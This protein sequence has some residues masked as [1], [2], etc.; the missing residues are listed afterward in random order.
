MRGRTPETAREAARKKARRRQ[1]E[2]EALMRGRAAAEQLAL[3]SPGWVVMYGP[4]SRRIW[5]FAAWASC[6]ALALDGADPQA[7][8][9]AMREAEREAHARG[10]V[11]RRGGAD[12]GGPHRHGYHPGPS[13]AVEPC[14]ARGRAGG[15]VPGGPA[16]APQRRGEGRGRAC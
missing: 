12:P 15:W 8:A 13:R 10:P 3:T 6:P 14:I 5:A 1:A 11:D 16:A 2:R 9:A 4:A 7:L